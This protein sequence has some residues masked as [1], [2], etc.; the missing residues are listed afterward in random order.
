MPTSP[1]TFCP[2][3]GVVFGAQPI[4]CVLAHDVDTGAEQ[5][6]PA[7]L[8]LYPYPVRHFSS[9]TNGLAS[10]NTLVE[11]TVHGLAEA[12]ERDVGSFQRAWDRSRMV[13]NDTLPEPV[14][15][16]VRD[17]EAKGCTVTVRYS[18]NEF[19][20]PYCNAVLR[21]IGAHNAVHLGYGCHPWSSI[22]VTRAVIEAFQGRLSFIHGGRDD[23]A[24]QT[25]RLSA[26]GS[27]GWHRLAEKNSQDPDPIDFHQVVD[28]SPDAPTLEDCHRILVAEARK[29]G[30]VLRVRYTPDDYPFHIVR[31]LVPGLEFNSADV[32]R[33]GRRL[34]SYLRSRPLM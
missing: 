24:M 21:E 7:E 30:P 9:D 17:A 3:P 2:R 6:V 13:R 28:R 16:I 1:V 29:V 26:R 25:R 4:D 31:M 32:P 8:V 18:Q 19:D 27:E 20:L 12:I 14:A 22:A 11:A 33:V 34:T 5:P 23:L 10:G 15:G